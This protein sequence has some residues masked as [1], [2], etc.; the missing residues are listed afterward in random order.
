MIAT[1]LSLLIFADTKINKNL[2]IA[3]EKSPDYSTLALMR[4]VKRA[5]TIV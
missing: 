4:V 1:V 3:D 5:N 2:T